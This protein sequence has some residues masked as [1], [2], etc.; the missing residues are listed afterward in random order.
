MLKR[1]R[2]IRKGG[3]MARERK[4]WRNPPSFLEERNDRRCNHPP[5]HVRHPNANA[6]NPQMDVVIMMIARMDPPRNLEHGHVPGNN[7]VTP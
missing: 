1:K 7:L 5:L 3:G 6:R 4:R 2:R